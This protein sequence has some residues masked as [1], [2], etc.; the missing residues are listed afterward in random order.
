M[1]RTVGYVRGARRLIAEDSKF[2]GSTAVFTKRR[3]RDAWNRTL[4]KRIAKSHSHTLKIKSRVRSKGQRGAGWYGEKKVAFLKRKVRTQNPW[5]LHLAG[6]FHQEYETEELVDPSKR[7]MMRAMLTA[8]IAVDQR[9]ANG[10]QGRIMM[11]HPMKTKDKRSALPASYKDLMAQP[12][13]HRSY[14]LL[15][16]SAFEGLD[17]LDS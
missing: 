17:R 9:F 15:S 5:L 11:F 4:V 13:Q 12:K 10:T 2:E 6:D 14:T 3:Y 1:N 7:H 16:Y 8:N